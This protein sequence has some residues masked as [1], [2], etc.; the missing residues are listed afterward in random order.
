M[1]SR[2]LVPVDGSSLSEQVMPYVQQ[3]GLGLSIPVTLMTVVE[4]ST[5]SIGLHL[6]QSPQEQDEI[7]HRA[8]HAVAYLTSLADALR[9]DGV[10]VSTVTPSGSPAQEI[11]REAEREAGTLIA[12]SGHGRSGMARWWLGS[13]ADR[14]LHTA[15]SPLLLIRFHEGEGPSHAQGF[16]RVV[17]AVDGSPLGEEILP[18]V[19]HI[20][21][22]LGM[23][24]DLVRVVPTM[25]EY[26]ALSAPSAS[27]GAAS[28]DTTSLEEAFRY[29]EEEATRYLERVKD[30]LVK[31]G[32]G[33][34]ETHCLRGDPASSIIDVAT[35]T[36]DRLVAMT[37]HGRSG[38]GRWVLGSV[39]DRVV[40][41]S[42][43]PVLVVRA[44]ERRPLQGESMPAAA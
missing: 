31:Q 13:I 15:E 11:V 28:L 20:T 25:A 8:D 10:A 22:A 6:G 29:N 14:V 9:S 3:L 2:I 43:D 18:H 41:N 32:V 21:K 5:P 23:A 40:R 39:A 36:P 37:S 19:A 1:Y 35:E 34:V 12:M 42:G 24:V 44:G 30:D 7:R 38:V 17:V 16:S 33:P 26:L 27:Y 4:P